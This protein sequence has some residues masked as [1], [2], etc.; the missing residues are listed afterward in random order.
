ML[1][2]FRNAD[3]YSPSPEGVK[4]V[5]VGGSTILAVETP[6]AIDIKGLQVQE[7]DL[8]GNLF[9]P[10]LV[11][12]HVHITGGGGEGG[13]RTR[14]PELSPGDMVEA[15]VTTVVGTRGT[16]GTTRTMQGLIA[17]TK[18][19]RDE[20]LSAYCYTGSYRLPLRTLTG[21]IQ[22]DIIL[23]EEVIGVGEVAVSDHRSSGGGIQELHHTTAEA[24]VGGMLSGKAGLVNVHM[25]DGTAGL[26]PI[27]QLVSATEL[28]IDQFLPTHINR[29]PSLFEQGIAFAKQG[30]RIDVT[31]ST[32]PQF[33]EEGEVAA[34]DAVKRLY[35]QGIP[36]DRIT[37]SSD[38]QGSLPAFDEYGR[39]TGLTIGTCQSVF[40]ALV[41]A[42]RA[43]GVP[44]DYALA[45]V[46]ASPADALKLTTKGRIA[47]GID[48]DIVV[49][50]KER[51]QLTHVM[52]MGR[53]WVEDGERVH[54]AAFE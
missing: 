28:P 36:A 29:N 46:T 5:L 27:L 11:D 37:M 21:N 1:T 26:G 41:D 42:V 6:G 17:K 4:D 40:D 34:A 33:I 14:T 10:G 50:D 16:D 35:H 32:T 2:L 3:V 31:T 7:V 15:G 23:I 43:H 30:G 20:G 25:G 47:P 48:A 18:A 38:G 9:M 39:L 12:S 45:T 54:F 24:R 19:L 49:L 51:L 53:F 8:Q 13:M 44:L 22:D 52:A